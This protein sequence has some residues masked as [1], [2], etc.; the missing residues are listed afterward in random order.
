MNEQV[1][2]KLLV[3]FLKE[4]MG[5][6]NNPYNTDGDRY[7][8]DQDDYECFAHYFEEWYCGNNRNNNFVTEVVSWGGEGQG[9]DIGFVLKI[10]YDDNV[11]YLMV[12]GY[13]DSWNGTEWDDDN[14]RIVTPK[15]KVITVWD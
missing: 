1:T 3:D 10:N 12:S 6:Y 11:Y 14:I 2:V 8:I 4:K 15:E 9:D 13:Y 5:E 7:I